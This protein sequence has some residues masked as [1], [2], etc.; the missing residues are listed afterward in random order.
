MQPSVPAGSAAPRAP[1][2]LIIEDEPD[3]AG[4]LKRVIE[5]CGRYRVE[6]AIGAGDLA[7]RLASAAPELILTD[8]MMPAM[9]GFE[10]IRR[11]KACD[12]D[13]PVVVVSAFATLENAVEA[14]KA[15]AFD[16]LAKPFSPESVEVILA[17]VER[18]RGLRAR[19]AQ[20]LEQLQE[21]D[22]DLRALLG[23]S[24][25]MRRLREW[26]CRVR[27][28]RTNVLIE[29]ESGTGKE[30]VARAIHA[31]Q[32]P[33]VAL[34][35]AAIPDELA[36][37]ELFGHRRGAFTGATAERD[38]LLLAAHGGTLFLDE[39]N[40]MS[41]AL[42]AKL[43]RVLEDRRVRPVGAD[44]ET[45]VEFRLISASNEDLERRVRDGSFRRDLYHRLK[46]LHA[47]IAPLHERVE[48]IPLLAEHFLHRYARAHGCRARR[49]APDALAALM[50]NAWPGNVRELENVIEQAAILCPREAVE[51]PLAV[52]PAALGG[53][54]GW[55]GEAAAPSAGATLAEVER[56]YIA[57]VLRQTGGNKAQAARILGID[58]KTLLR[59]IAGQS[60]GER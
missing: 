32:G 50:R 5:T 9:D 2:I 35:V 8:L 53:G 14:V 46:V 29:G 11:V 44:H 18:E 43:L 28:V 30:L 54:Q 19:S 21:R 27:T 26:V 31:G 42:Q 25:P 39:V 60:A 10:V 17:K 38:G 47:R 41:A 23:E 37:S 45:E 16:F 49:F 12:P 22:S 7:E 51:I 15:G 20:L 34:N 58:Y 6:I 56:H 48:D 1:G 40:A 13:L 3:V 59:K 36:E 57:S 4:M 33:F 24:A 55:L 52:F